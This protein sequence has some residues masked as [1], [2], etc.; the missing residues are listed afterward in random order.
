M[1][2]DFVSGLRAQ[3]VGAAEREQARRVSWRSPEPRLL[4]AGL[5]GAAALAAV[6]VLLASGGLRTEPAPPQPANPPAPEARDL[7]GGSLE[8]DVRYRT[9]AFVPALSFVVG[10]DLWLVLDSTQ[11]EQLVL[12]RRRVEQGE[13]RIEGPA[14]GYLAFS[15]LE[16]VHEP[17][18]RGLEASLVDAPGDLYAWLRAHPDLRV[19]EASPVTVGG[20]PGVTF[21]VVVSFDRPVHGDPDCWRQFLIRCTT[22]SPVLSLPDGAHLRFTILRTEPDPLV[23]TLDARGERAL[24]GLEDAAAPLLES[25]RIGVG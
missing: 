9:N 2:D 7:F 17:G 8:P 23:I 12:E 13:L 25:L 19:G 20:V 4:L 11:P 14:S 3:L 16:Q 22:L 1:S 24:S 15:R 10:D 5:A 18:T 21:R 6:I